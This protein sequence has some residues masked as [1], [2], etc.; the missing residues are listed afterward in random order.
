MSSVVVVVVVIVVVIFRALSG[1]N[2]HPFASPQQKPPYTQALPVLP[3][4]A[5]QVSEGLMTLG[6]L[7]HKEEDWT[8][9]TWFSLH[10]TLETICCLWAGSGNPPASLLAFELQA[11]RTSW[12]SSIS[13]DAPCP[14]PCSF[15]DTLVAAFC[16]SPD[17]SARKN[18]SFSCYLTTVAYGQLCYIT[19]QTGR[20]L[21]DPARGFFKVLAAE[22]VSIRHQPSE[23][24]V[25]HSY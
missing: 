10:P 1:A 23:T 2:G 8:G 14:C 22:Y 4:A 5:A 19:H 6:P 17:W 11:G 15:D 25:T 21:G 24:M 7:C 18:P 9:K 3:Q 13:C 20:N 16:A 12:D